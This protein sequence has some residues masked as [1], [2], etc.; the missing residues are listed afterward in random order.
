MSQ[1]SANVLPATLLTAVLTLSAPTWAQQ[2]EIAPPP[3][4]I[5]AV[6][7]AQGRQEMVDLFQRV[8]GRLKEIDELLYEA[9]TG[10][11]TIG[12]LEDS[13]IHELLQS[14]SAKAQEVLSGIDR[15]LEI[16]E[17]QGGSCSS[18]MSG[19]PQS[20][21]LDRQPGGEKG[22]K[23]QTPETPGEKEGQQPK[24]EPQQPT[25]SEGQPDSPRE[26]ADDP[27]NR[28]SDQPPP[29]GETGRVETIDSSE[30]WGDLPIHV[31]DLFRTEGG[32][33]MPPQY[34]DW[35]DAYYRRLNQR[36]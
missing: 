34:R 3:V 19:P 9:S 11:A 35:I 33:D 23:E 25:G 10:E 26:G 14:S 12:E 15:I 21:P 8:E 1:S 32:S 22:E 27:Q 30:R 13:G 31:R 2:P 5:Q 20:S 28:E 18:T 29:E 16:A 7:A 4:G 6:D 36:P 24:P 17:Q